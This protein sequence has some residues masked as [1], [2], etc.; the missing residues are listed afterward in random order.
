VTE[1]EALYRDHIAV[2]DREVFPMAARVLRAEDRQTIGKE[3]A[4]RR[5]VSGRS[6]NV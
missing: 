2:E 4:G 3:M 1:L 5:G 6:S